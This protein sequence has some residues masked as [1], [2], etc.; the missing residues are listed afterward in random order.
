MM[1]RCCRLRWVLHWALGTDPRRAANFPRAA[2]SARD[3]ST[4]RVITMDFEKAYLS[5]LLL[6]RQTGVGYFR[7]LWEG[8]LATGSAE[9][10]ERD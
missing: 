7:C 3:A 4:V 8:S 9:R 5:V 2:S 10:K 1:A 6:V